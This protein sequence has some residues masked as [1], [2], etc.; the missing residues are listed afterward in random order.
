MRARYATPVFSPS[1]PLVCRTLQFRPSIWAVL[2]NELQMLGEKWSWQQDDPAAATVAEVTEEIINETDRAVFAGCI[3]I[4][5]VKWLTTEAPDWCLLCDGT[6]YDGDD[7]PDL[8]AVIDVAYHT[9]GGMFVVP[10][11]LFRFPRGA[12]VPGT[13]GGQDNV[14]LTVNELPS[15]AHGLHQHGSHSH[16]ISP[17]TEAGGIPDISAGPPLP[18]AT[19][20]ASVENTGEGNAFNITPLYHDL[21]PVIVARLPT[22]G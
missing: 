9:G 16:G 5:E 8:Y 1:D 14:I 19:D 2:F 20:F 7:Y 3:M 13:Q 12:V 18:G 15:H 6:E 4:G 22:A 17:D 21:I 11:L 10:D